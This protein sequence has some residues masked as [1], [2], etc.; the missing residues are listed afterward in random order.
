MNSKPNA[1]SIDVLKL[2][3]N[4]HRL[5]IALLLANGEHSSEDMVD[6]T[7]LSRQSF[8]HH[9]TRFRNRGFVS[10]RRE[11]RS[12]M[13]S[14][15]GPGGEIEQLLAIIV[16][17]YPTLWRSFVARH[18]EAEAFEPAEVDDAAISN[19]HQERVCH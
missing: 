3:G 15:D 11:G 18:T 17:Q 7:G 6:A 12:V 16:A 19:L 1:T 5:K 10:G 8:T 14:L 9:L 4:E 13:Y 2:L